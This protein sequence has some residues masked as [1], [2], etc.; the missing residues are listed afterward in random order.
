MD[1]QVESRDSF[2]W[3]GFPFSTGNVVVRPPP[4]VFT[5]S[6]RHGGLFISLSSRQSKKL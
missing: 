6:D 4:P 3:I 2:P 1:I 5:V